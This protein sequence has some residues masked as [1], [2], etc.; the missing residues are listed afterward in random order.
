MPGSVEKTDWAL[1]VERYGRS[2]ETGDGRQETGDRRRETGGGSQE[3]LVLG[4][5]RGMESDADI[6]AERSVQRRW[7]MS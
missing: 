4:A 6:L 2:Q 7:S 3:F 5:A 1:R